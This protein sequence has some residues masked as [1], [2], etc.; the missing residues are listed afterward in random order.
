MVAAG[1]RVSSG[2]DG[3][4]AG[5]MTI[6][7]TVRGP[8]VNFVRGE[9][10]G[11][12]LLVAATAAALVWANVGAGR[13][14]EVWETT[15]G[16]RLGSE[17]LELTL[18]EWVNSGLMALFFFVVGLEARREADIGELR[19]ARATVLP[20]LAGLAGLALPAGIFLAINA[21][22]EAGHAWGVA[23]STDTAF[24]LG[25]LTL[26]GPLYADRL[27]AFIVTVL[28]A[29]DVVALLVIALVYSERLAT[30]P[31]LMA[32][33]LFAVLVAVR[34]LGVRH[35]IVYAALGVAIW[36]AMV[37]SGV[38]PLVV[39]LAMGLLVYAYPSPRTNLEQASEEFRRFREQPT[40]E[41]A[42]RARASLEAAVSPNDRL[43]TLWLPWVI[44]LIVPLFAL[45]NAGVELSGR[46]LAAAVT[47]PVTLG[48][49]L[50]LLIGK[51]VAIT[52]T[53]Y[54]V[55]RLS[56]RR[57]RPP[58]GWG[59]VLGAGAAAGIGFTIALLIATLA[60]EGE[61]LQEAKIGVLATIVLAPLLSA[62]VFAVLRR[63]PT[64][65]KVRALLGDPVDLVDLAEPV[66]P[67]VDH[68]RGPVGAPVTLVEY[69]DFECPYCGLA[70]PV[71]R[72]LLREFTDLT[73]VWRHLPLDDVHP[74][75][76][77]AAEAT[78]AAAAQGA[79]WE[80]HDLL[81]DH[82]GALD[83]D[84]LAG[85]AADLGLDVDRF[86]SDLT[87]RR[88]ANRVARDVESA[89]V[90][91]VGGTPTFFVNGRR[92]HGAYDLDTLSAAVKSAGARAVM[93]G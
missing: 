90:S 37:R 9:M 34:A 73:Y 29:D 47:S 93:A 6:A 25:V 21:G 70:E 49:V 20:L 62:A 55:S 22:T 84:D 36:V 5:R 82:Q 80:M 40:G 75:A 18:R 64:R 17:E 8:L 13:Y 42:R 74:H 46:T 43:A 67:E 57:L 78:E 1:V 39:G 7:R 41:M 27:R 19:Q 31:L 72:D 15:L 32:L 23:M 16:I 38:D 3:A 89:D 91:G 2:T 35:G 76:R 48:V 11:A 10:R 30:G 85:Y 63:L 44:N 50:G 66:D 56:G 83:L 59:A 68:A 14:D 24:T 88:H 12:A 52:A 51:P 28:V 65:R 69:G 60:L 58:V 53:S 26:V 92:H 87:E 45:A 4:A 79:F 61:Q 54:L 77:L 86:V 81:L 33:G 71:V